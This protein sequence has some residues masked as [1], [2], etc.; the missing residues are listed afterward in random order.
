MTNIEAVLPTNV[1]ARSFAEAIVLVGPKLD[2]VTFKE[3]MSGIPESAMKKRI[4]GWKR[5]GRL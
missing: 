1:Q 2:T 5:V 4:I 3:I